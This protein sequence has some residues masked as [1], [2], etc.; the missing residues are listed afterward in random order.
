MNLEEKALFGIPINTDYGDFKP[1]TVHDYMECAPFLQAM[2]YDKKRVLHEIRLAQ[3]EENRKLKEMTETL[4][5]LNEEMSLKE[6]LLSLMPQYINAY[7]EVLIRCRK[8]DIEL[9]GEDD[10]EDAEKVYLTAQN[11]LLELEPNQ[12]DEVRDILLS[13]NAQSKQTAFLD[14]EMQWRKERSLKFN[15]SQS[16]AEAPNP[17]T[18][19]TSVVT[20]TG[21]NFEEVVNWNI[22][23]LQH[24]FQRVALFHSYQTYITFATV[25]GDKIDPVNWAENVITRDD[26]NTDS[27]FAIEFE[28]FKSRI[29]DQLS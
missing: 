10:K 7:I 20:Y 21:I 5:K 17:S 8:F 9:A 29:G 27:N 15:H 26:S 19:V 16:D 24:M 6:I 13:I 3:P 23:Q 4:R 25:A 12:F 14:P 22:T 28:A 11:F 2:S 1:M 18:L